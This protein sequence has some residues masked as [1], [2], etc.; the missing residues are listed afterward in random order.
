[1]HD[2]KE[3]EPYMHGMKLEQDNVKTVGVVRGFDRFHPILKPIRFEECSTFLP[4]YK[5]EMN[6][7]YDGGS[8]TEANAHYVLEILAFAEDAQHLRNRRRL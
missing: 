7:T 3:S 2:R 8:E 1:M 4:P 6:K 5:G